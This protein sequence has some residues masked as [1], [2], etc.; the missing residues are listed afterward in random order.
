MVTL[1]LPQTPVRETLSEAPVVPPD[2]QARAAA[3]RA[4]LIAQHLPLV[5]YVAGSLSRHRS[6]AAVVDYDDLVGYGTEGLIAAVDSFNPSYHVKF[7][8][9]AVMHIRTTI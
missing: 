4:A 3:T 6:G 1:P 9:W 2:T 5:R 7:S 8:T